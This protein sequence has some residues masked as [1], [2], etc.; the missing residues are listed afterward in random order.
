METT[1]L[2]NRITEIKLSGW[3]QKES[4]ALA[5]VAQLVSVSC[6]LKGHGFDSWSQGTCLGYRC[7][8]PSGRVWEATVDVSLPLCL[9]LSVSLSPSLSLSLSKIN[10]HVLRWGLK[11]KKVE[12][13]WQDRTS[14][15]GIHWWNLLNLDREKTV[16]GKMRKLLKGCMLPLRLSW[17]TNRWQ[18]TITKTVT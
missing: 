8:P 14:E 6:K 1:E 13:R 16:W 9:P 15:L 5:S 18:C 2:K 17:D 3:A 12:W 7:G 4:G 10:K 11:K